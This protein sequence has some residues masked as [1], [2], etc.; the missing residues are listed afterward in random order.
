MN[1]TLRLLHRYA[2][3]GKNSLLLGVFVGHIALAGGS[4]LLCFWRELRAR[5]TQ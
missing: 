5:Q 4:L 2:W 3:A 1:S